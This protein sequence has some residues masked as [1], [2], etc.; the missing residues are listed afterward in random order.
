MTSSIITAATPDMTIHDAAKLFVDHH[1]SGMPVLGANGQ[2]IGI[3]SQG[4]LLH[5]VENGTGHGKRRWWLELLS[6]SA[7]EQAARYVKEHG[8]V[9]GDVMCENVISTPED[10]PLHQIA[11]LMERRHLK[12][13]PMLKDGQLVGIVSR[14]NLIRAL[15]SVEPAI[16]TGSHDDASLRDAI[17]REMHGQRWGLAKHGVFV[18]DG[19]AHLW[20]IVESEDEKCAIRIAAENVPGIKRVESHLESPSVIPTM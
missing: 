11:D 18:K 14:S 12:R 7:R 20:G 6:S 13:V 9:V 16:D 3:V 1:I 10:M 17:L 2:V 8:H 5:R 4:D 15:A 19:V